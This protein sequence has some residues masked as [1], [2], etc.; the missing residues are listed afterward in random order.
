MD[1]VLAF[2][3]RANASEAHAASEG[4]DQAGEMRRRPAG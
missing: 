2:A 3:L 4:Y 1:N